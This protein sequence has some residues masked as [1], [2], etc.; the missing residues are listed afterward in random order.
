MDKL[1]DKCLL[2]VNDQVIIGPSACELQKV[3]TKMNDSVKKRGM[4]VNVSKTK[5][6]VFGKSE[7]TTEC[8]IHAEDEKVEQVKDFV[9]LGSTF[10]ND[11]KHG[12]DIE[13][14][15][16]TKNKVNG[17]LFT[18]MNSKSISRQACFAAHNEV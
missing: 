11:G 5:M 13:R 7:S 14:R 18:I 1:S 15:V 6:T 2:C 16:D 12:R 3:V 9:Y 17:A 4:K 10:T 8:D